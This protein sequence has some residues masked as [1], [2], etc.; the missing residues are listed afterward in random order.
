MASL[1]SAIF[2]PPIIFSP[3]TSPL[4]CSVQAQDSFFINQ[5][6]SQHIPPFFCLNKKEGFNFNIARLHTTKQVSRKSCSYN[7]YICFIFLSSLRETITI[8]SSTPS[9][10]AQ[11]YNITYVNRKYILSNFQNSRIDRDI[12]LPG[13]SP[14]VLL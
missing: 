4:F 11:G 6:Y 12:S 13:Q 14:K 8:Y 7:T 5:W 9:N 2:L 1:Y 10:T 3:P